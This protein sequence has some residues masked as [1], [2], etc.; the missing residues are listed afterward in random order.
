MVIN[1]KTSN[2]KKDRML[3]KTVLNRIEKHKSFVYEDA[4]WDEEGSTLVVPIRARRN[5]KAACSRC[6]QACPGYDELP[7]RRWEHVPLWGIKVFFEYAMRRVECQ[8]CGIVVEAVPWNCGKRAATKSFGWFLA[9]W[10]RRLS[11]QE[12]AD[13]FRVTWRRVFQSV[14][15]AVEWGL[16]HRDLE[17]ITAIGVD[18]IQWRKGH[19]YLTV[20]YQIDESH[21]RLLWVGKDRTRETFERFFHWFGEKKTAAL[22]FICSDMWES[23]VNVIAEQAGHAF[24]VLDRYHLVANMNKAIDKV[25]AKEVKRLKAEG[26]EPVLKRTRWLFLR[27]PERMNATQQMKLKDLLQLNLK[28]VR[29]YL[30]KEDFDDFWHYV[31]PYWAGRFLDN[32]CKKA[33]R[34]R[35]EPMKDIARSFRTHRNLIL[36]WFKARKAAVSLGA[37]EGFNNKG[38]V[39]LRKSYGFRT[40]KAAEIA[41]YH[42]LG[43]LP[44]PILTHNY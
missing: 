11:W 40:L 29:A 4:V 34:S 20:V 26:H 9:Q 43:D 23:Y 38:K 35:I 21:K 8:R 32:W 1:T 30:L 22:R 7:V 27:R 3:I 33:M 17:G 5:G 15:M 10:A 16:E 41:L 19:E 25:R 37:V 12:T 2:G 24:N 31:S 18:E 36:N 44:E 39:T 28:T 14:E 42:T 6:G 13:A